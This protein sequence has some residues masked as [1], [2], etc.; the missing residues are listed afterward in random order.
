MEPGEFQAVRV[1]ALVLVGSEDSLKH[2]AAAGA[3]ANPN[4]QLSVVAGASH[5]FEEPGTLE[6]ATRQTVDWFRTQLAGVPSP[7]GAR[8]A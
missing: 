4:L 8:G 7:A 1:P 5:L 2:Q 3:A 6:E